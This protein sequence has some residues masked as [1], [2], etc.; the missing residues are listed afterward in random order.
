[1]VWTLKGRV[2][3][4]R[5]T[6]T[7]WQVGYAAPNSARRQSLSASSR[8]PTKT[9]SWL[10][11]PCFENCSCRNPP[12]SLGAVRRFERSL[13]E[14]SSVNLSQAISI[15]ALEPYQDGGATSGLW[16]HAVNFEGAFFFSIAD[17][18]LSFMCG[19]LRWIRWYTMRSIK[20]FHHPT[21][22]FFSLWNHMCSLSLCG[23]LQQCLRCDWNIGAEV[24]CKH[25]H[26]IVIRPRL[27]MPS[28]AQE[29]IVASLPHLAQAYNL[30]VMIGFNFRI[31][32]S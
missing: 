17:A 6:V 30:R 27:C 15:Q 4:D 2:K 26:V 29:H 21:S 31:C 22:I 1:M 13:W 12:V 24:P 7:V 5:Y 20:F 16:R 3:W 19:L 23:A 18:I 11:C 10:H 8:G 25:E 14:V 32:K 28:T 9:T